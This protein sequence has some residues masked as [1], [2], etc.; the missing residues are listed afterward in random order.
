M[1]PRDN[2]QNRRQQSMSGAEISWVGAKSW[3]GMTEYSKV[4]AQRGA[5][6]HEEGQSGQRG[7]Q[8]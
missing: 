6:G 4:A 8:K 1:R 7:L 2:N 5:G 3:A